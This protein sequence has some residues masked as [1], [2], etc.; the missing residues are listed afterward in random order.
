MGNIKESKDYFQN[1]NYRVK[2]LEN[3][4]PTLPKSVRGLPVNLH[5]PKDSLVTQT[6]LLKTKQQLYITHI[7]PTKT[8]RGHETLT[9][10]Y[11]IKHPFSCQFT[12]S[13]CIEG[14]YCVQNMLFVKLILHWG[15]IP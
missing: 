2:T 3:K 14:L 6:L 5:S 4:A 11:E 8:T 10:Y 9:V 15:E 1:N 7:W 12:F 13:L